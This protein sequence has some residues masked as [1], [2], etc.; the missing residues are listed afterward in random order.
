MSKNLL[1]A[2][3]WSIVTLVASMSVF[4]LTNSKYTD[5]LVMGMMLSGFLTAYYKYELYRESKIKRWDK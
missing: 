2:I 3:L 4:C 5:S 1:S